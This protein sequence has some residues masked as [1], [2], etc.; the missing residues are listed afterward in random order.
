MIA[1]PSLIRMS[2]T[3]AVLLLSALPARAQS[4]ACSV[5]GTYLLTAT[6]M[7]IPPAQVAGSVIFTPPVACDESAVGSAEVRA[8]YSSAS[9]PEVF[10][11]TVPYRV[12]GVDVVIGEGLMVGTLSG[13][14]DR[15][16]MSIPVNGAGALRL[17]GVLVR[18][19]IETGALVPMG[20]TGATGPTGPQ[21]PIGDTG[22][23]GP[24]GPTGATG[25]QGPAGAT[26]PQGPPGTSEPFS[27]AHATRT[28]G[29]AVASTAFVPFTLS[30]SH[31]TDIVSVGPP[32]QSF[33]LMAPGVY[34]VTYSIRTDPSTVSTTVG[35]HATVPMLT[36]FDLVPATGGISTGVALVTVEDVPL[37]V[38][39]QNTGANVMTLTAVAQSAHMIIERIK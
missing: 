3:A 9:G 37:L 30:Q 34:K 18:R 8:V 14:I 23:V 7:T 5:E 11:Q 6:L 13:L 10:Q 28:G 22:P 35:V 19:T 38:S 29:M 1:K 21:G 4:S 33:R 27:L 32:I 25:P 26:G 20:A 36:S 15:K 39:L 24:A 2:L 31:G 16:A 12:D 17:A